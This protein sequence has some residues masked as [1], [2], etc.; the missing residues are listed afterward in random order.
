MIR[1]FMLCLCV[2]QLKNHIRENSSIADI[3]LTL[4]LGLIIDL[5]AI[6]DRL[7]KQLSFE[8]SV[9]ADPLEFTPFGNFLRDVKEW[10]L[11][12]FRRKVFSGIILRPLPPMFMFFRNWEI[13]GGEII[14][15]CNECCWMDGDIDWQDMRDI[16]LSVSSSLSQVLP[17]R[18]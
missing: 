4:N 8:L 7:L 6:D 17:G 12:S 1:C 13:Y 18:K 2:H 16:T 14:R 11:K 3:L 5:L 10:R 9:I 15:F